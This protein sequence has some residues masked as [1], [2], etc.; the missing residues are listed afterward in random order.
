MNLSPSWRFKFLWLLSHKKC[1]HHL[2]V[3]ADYLKYKTERERDL[4]VS[5]KHIL[6]Q[7]VQPP[8]NRNGMKDDVYVDRHY[9]L[10]DCAETHGH[11]ILLEK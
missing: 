7:S 10:E 8:E 9:C 2:P 11:K 6:L 3:L 5:G 1:L 4:L